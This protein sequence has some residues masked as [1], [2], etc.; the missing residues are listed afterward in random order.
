M[1]TV[2][3]EAGRAGDDACADEDVMEGSM[4]LAEGGL[5]AGSIATNA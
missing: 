3:Q 1:C 2:R 5:G 4:G